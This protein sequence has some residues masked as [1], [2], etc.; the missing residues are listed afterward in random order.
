MFSLFASKISPVQIN[1]LKNN[2]MK[3]RLIYSMTLLFAMI[4]F[5]SVSNSA[6]AQKAQKTIKIGTYDSRVIVLA[7]S[8]SEGFKTKLS[9][10]EKK[11]ESDMKSSDSDKKDQAAYRMITYQFLLHQQVFCAGSAS[12]VI[13][14]V[15]DKLPQVAKDAGV[16]V[17]VS[18]WEL[19]WNDPSAE[20]VDLTMEIAKLFNPTPDFE[21]TAKEVASK[22]PIAI[23]ELTVE[24]VVQMWKQHE[25]QKTKK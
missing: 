21:N 11:S 10:M 12:A 20:V 14:I 17:I 7:Y 9:G 24:E 1:N 16:S 2:A 6:D 3:P 25:S 22:R 15:K 18:K 23:E 5:M 13:E 19:P 8:R 4:L